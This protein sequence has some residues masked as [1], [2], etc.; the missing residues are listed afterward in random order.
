MSRGLVNCGFFLVRVGIQD[1]GALGG[2]GSL[3]VGVSRWRKHLGS[4]A[5]HQMVPDG[6]LSHREGFTSLQE[7]RYQGQSLVVWLPQA[8]A[9]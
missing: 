3:A 9:G 1:S 5:F 6:P 2:E 4:G 7:S 8:T